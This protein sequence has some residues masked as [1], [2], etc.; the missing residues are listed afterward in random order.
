MRESRSPVQA[1]GC[2]SRGDPEN[3]AS[4]WKGGTR[5]TAIEDIRQEY[6]RVN[7]TTAPILF[8]KD[9][10]FPGVTRDRPQIKFSTG[11]KHKFTAACNV[12][13]LGFR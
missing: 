2:I 8:F 7:A 12:A 5:Y 1:S 10:F 6:R 9:V 3:L 4:G 13:L 11:C